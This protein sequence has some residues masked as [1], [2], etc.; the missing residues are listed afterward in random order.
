MS[1]KIVVV[2]N[3]QA[4]PFSILLEKAFYK[5]EVTCVAI[6]HLLKND[7]ITEYK[8][9]FDDSDFI[10]TQNIADNYPCEFVR[11]SI[12]K[13]LYGEKLILIPNLFYRG[14][15]PELRYVRLGSQGTLKG[16]LG[17]YQHETILQSYLMGL[18]TKKCIEL[19]KSPDY[20][21]RQYGNIHSESLSELIKREY[22][23]DVKV[24]GELREMITQDRLFFTFNH[25]KVKLIYL[26]T[27]KLSNI[28]GFTKDLNFSIDD[29]NESPL[30]YS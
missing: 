24:T 7:H 22:F 17:D 18:S 20:W 2:G 9:F 8:A 25:P 12:L 4:R 27:E 30:K 3:C 16:P 21:L 19:M 1:I 11:T 10:V 5:I 29:I 23:V 14:Y 15:T 28:V 13:N 26:M 6:V